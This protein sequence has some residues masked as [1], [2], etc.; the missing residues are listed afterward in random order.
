MSGYGQLPIL[1]FTDKEQIASIGQIQICSYM[2]LVMKNGKKLLAFG[3]FNPRI[4]GV[5]IFSERIETNYKI[6]VVDSGPTQIPTKKWLVEGANP[7]DIKVV[8]LC[9]DLDLST[10]QG[11]TVEINQKDGQLEVIA[12]DSNEKFSSPTCVYILVGPEQVMG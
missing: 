2:A 4:G 6:T 9:L 11:A 8:N 12:T 5:L 3:N 10:A 1:W 7:A